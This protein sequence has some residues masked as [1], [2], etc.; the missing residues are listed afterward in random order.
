MST[1][2][3]QRSPVH[4]ATEDST[5]DPTGP[6]PAAQQPSQPA[7]RH[8]GTTDRAPT[9]AAANDDIAR[10]AAELKNRPDTAEGIPSNFETGAAMAGRV[11][12]TDS[13]A[14][15]DAARQYLAQRDGKVIVVDASGAETSSD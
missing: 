14:D 10:R 6:G 9:R 11:P 1:S 4:A 3:A 15:A 7:Q 5:A 13:D 12:D 8:P 2:D